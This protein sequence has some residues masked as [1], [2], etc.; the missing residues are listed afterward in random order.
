MKKY[1]RGLVKSHKLATL[2][3]AMDFTRDLE[4]VFPRTKY[5]PNPNFP[6]KFK[7]GK[8]LWKITPF[9]NKINEG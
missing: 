2:K 9:P 5:P 6:S 7:E 4:N 1:F 3:D 8:K